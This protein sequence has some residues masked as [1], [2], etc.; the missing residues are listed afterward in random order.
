[1]ENTGT[2]SLNDLQKQVDTLG[3]SGHYIKKYKLMKNI[4]AFPCSKE[5]VHKLRIH[6][7]KTYGL[8]CVQ[9]LY[10]IGL[11]WLFITPPLAMEGAVDSFISGMADIMEFLHGALYIGIVIGLCILAGSDNPWLKGTGILCLEGIVALTTASLF[12][13]MFDTMGQASAMRMIIM[14]LS[15]T[16]AIFAGASFYGLFTKRDLTKWEGPLFGALLSLVIAGFFSPFIHNIMFTV[17]YTLAST[18]IFTLFTMYDNQLIKVRFLSKYRDDIPDTKLS[19]W[20]L[21]A[22]SSFD[23]VLDFVNLF[24][25]LLTLGIAEADENN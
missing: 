16:I 7:A 24:L 25:D 5:E 17:I 18:V 14:A 10:I 12:S 9:L 2:V 20:L 1:M 23:L 6:I 11:I 19:W 3:G 13:E 15:E 21:A 22:D 8:F 4:M